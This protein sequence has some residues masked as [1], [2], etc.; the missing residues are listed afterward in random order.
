MEKVETQNLASHKE[1]V[2]ISGVITCMINSAIPACETHGMKIW[3][4]TTSNII[5]L[6]RTGDARFCVSTGR[7]TLRREGGDGKCAEDT[8]MHGYAVSEVKNLY[9]IKSENRKREGIYGV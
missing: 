5:E 1:G 8:G 3:R 6:S 7:T 9:I 2:L 4:V